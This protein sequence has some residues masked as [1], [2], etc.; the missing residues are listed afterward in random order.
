MSHDPD[1]KTVLR[2]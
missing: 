2:C 1:L